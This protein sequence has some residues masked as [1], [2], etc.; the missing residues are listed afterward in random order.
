MKIRI[1]FCFI[2]WLVLGKSLIAFDCNDTFNQA[3]GLFKKGEISKAVGLYQD[4]ITDCTNGDVKNKALFELG[5]CYYY[6]KDYSKSI[7]MMDNLINS[8]TNK[9]I[10]IK[11]INFKGDVYYFTKQYD[12]AISAYNGL[13]EKYKDN[14]LF[15][16][17]LQIVKSYMKLKDSDKA[18]ELLFKMKEK[19]KDTKYIKQIEYYIQRL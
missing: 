6:L 10:K 7:K 3:K 5:K 16:T 17:K 13:V 8:V 15:T 1:L 14:D 2:V 4:I 11:A 19:Y 18:G 12:K 9:E